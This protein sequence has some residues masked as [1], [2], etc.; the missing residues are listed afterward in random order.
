ME[1]VKVAYTAGYWSTNI[2]NAF[3]NM[4][5]D[6]VLRQVFGN[7]NVYMVFDQSAYIPGQRTRNGNIKYALNYWEHINVEYVVLLGPVL[8]QNFLPIWKNTL[9][10]LKK[11][12]I[13][14]MILSA[15]MMKYN[16]T[17]LK[18]IKEYF[19]E[20]PPFVITTRDRDTYDEFKDV[21]PN[22]YDGICFSFFLPDCY[23]PISTD[24]GQ[25]MAFNFD[26]IDE[27]Y[28]YMDDLPA[29]IDRQFEFNGHIYGL[30][31]KKLDKI[32]LKT[33]RFTDAL[34][35]MKSPLPRGHRQ[36]RIGDYTIIRTDHRFNP[37]FIRKVYRYGNSF[38]GDIPHTYAN[39]Y[40]QASLTISDRVHACAVTLAY[41]ND[42][43]LLANTTRSSLLERVGANEIYEHP[44][45]LDMKKVE[46]EKTALLKWMKSIKY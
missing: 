8:S 45:K 37:M 24:L 13:K 44:V 16:D 36:D 7:D 18:Q 5:A 42:A 11:R 39:I 29:N 46:A 9:D 2:G 3:Y 20:N 34:V 30:K 14:Y 43:V 40:S 4:G 19:S 10:E 6:Y 23:K 32:S 27:P 35:Y 17:I 33:D 41:G 1:N 28:I 22:I 31:L 26:K 15:G 12:R 21:V 38:C 25:T